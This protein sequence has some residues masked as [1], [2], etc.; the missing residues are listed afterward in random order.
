MQVNSFNSFIDPNVFSS[1][2]P[3]MEDSPD[4]F[5]DEDS[6]DFNLTFNDTPLNADLEGL[7]RD[8]EDELQDWF[9]NCF[10]SE[11]LGNYVIQ[12]QSTSSGQELVFDDALPTS[13]KIAQKID[14]FS[15]VREGLASRR[16]LIRAS[17]FDQLNYLPYNSSSS[18]KKLQALLESKR[19]ALRASSDSHQL[20]S[21]LF[22]PE[23]NQDVNYEI[24]SIQKDGI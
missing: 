4:E 2:P 19:M 10:G 16:R 11:D 23:E 12:D 14:S 13:R 21:S 1:T 18:I 22:P 15:I 3:R 9:S 17:Q 7:T 6:L 24:S 20:Y 5:R 8:I